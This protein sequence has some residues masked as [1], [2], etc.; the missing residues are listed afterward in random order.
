MTDYYTREP[1]SGYEVIFDTED[2]ATYEAVKKFCSQMCGGLEPNEPKYELRSHAHWVGLHGT[3]VPLDEFGR[4]TDLAFCS[5]CEEFLTGSD[6]YKKA[7][8]WYCPNC[9]AKMNKGEKYNE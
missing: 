3:F 2:K 9:G 1:T 6:E 8:G 7:T 5:R 4:P